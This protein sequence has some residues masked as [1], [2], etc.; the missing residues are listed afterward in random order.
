MCTP[1]AMQ[2][3][4]TWFT[5]MSTGQRSM[6]SWSWELR[7]TLLIMHS[8]GRLVASSIFISFV[9]RLS[10]SEIRMECK[11]EEEDVRW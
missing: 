11:P 5:Y 1:L 9:G 7:K 2:I 4:G 10:S 8:K 3:D 6:Q